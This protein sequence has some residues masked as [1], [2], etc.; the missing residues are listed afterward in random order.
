MLHWTIDN[1]WAVTFLDVIW[2]NQSLYCFAAA[3][4]FAGGKAGFGWCGSKSV[5]H[6]GF[7]C[8]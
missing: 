2:Q 6:P 8:G 5:F 4:F 1:R 7:I 3:V